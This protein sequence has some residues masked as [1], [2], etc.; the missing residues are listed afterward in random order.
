MNGRGR[1]CAQAKSRVASCYQNNA[2]S[3]LITLAFG[4]AE[5][6]IRCKANVDQVT[7]PASP[8][9]ARPRSGHGTYGTCGMRD[10]V[11]LDREPGA[12]RRVA[13]RPR[14]MR[15][16]SVDGAAMND[17]RTRDDVG[18][19]EDA[20]CNAQCCKHPVHIPHAHMTHDH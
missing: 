11:A 7:Y 5:P 4:G 15:A 2:S 1:G 6:R 17:R 16:F 13:S 19:G 8:G 12:S 3:V 18:A 20:V 10:S 9:A 14:A